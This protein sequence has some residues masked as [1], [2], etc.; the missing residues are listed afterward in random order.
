VSF[1]EVTSIGGGAFSVCTSLTTA[2]FPK[3]TNI[4]SG[5]FVSCTSLATANF[6]EAATIGD[7]AFYNCTELFIPK[8]ANIGA[9]A[10]QYSGTAPLTITMWSAAPTVGVDMFKDI[11][12]AKNVTVRVPNGATGYDTA[13]QNAFKGYGTN[14]PHG[15]V[16][17]NIN[18]AIQYY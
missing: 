10:F 13:W 12:G 15:T 3:A 7:M 8:A 4:G 11:T 14:T 6:P 18:L 17:E 5:A 2:T 16:N 9:K 1:P